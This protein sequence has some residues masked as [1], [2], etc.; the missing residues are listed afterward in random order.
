MRSAALNKK[1]VMSDKTSPERIARGNV[2]AELEPD[3]N[4]HLSKL[5]ARPDLSFDRRNTAR[6]REKKEPSVTRI[7]GK[8]AFRILSE[9]QHG[10]AQL[11]ERCASLRP[12]SRKTLTQHLRQL[13]RAGLIVRIGR[14]TTKRQASS[15]P[16]QIRSAS[17]QCTSSTL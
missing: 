1:K 8:W 10:S 4:V 2:S 6:A 14:R 9:L 16:C 11:S 12:A 13:E 7:E 15:I 5:R 3:G 17:L